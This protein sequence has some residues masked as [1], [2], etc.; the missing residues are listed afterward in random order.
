MDTAQP[1]VAAETDPNAQ[2]A[3]AAEAFKA[4]DSPASV[5][6]RD[7]TGR[8]ASDQ[9]EEELTDDPEYTELVEDGEDVDDEAEEAAEEPAQP[10][11]PSWGADDT[12]LWESLPPEAQARIAEREGERDRGLNQK[13]QEAANTRKAYEQQVQEASS[14]LQELTS[15]IDTVEAIYKAPEPDPRAFGYGTRQYNEAAYRTAYQQWQQ[16]EN[17]L[18]QLHQ[19]REAATAKQNEAEAQAFTEWK[20]QHEAQYAPKLL[21]DVP[22]LKDTA[23]AD[24]VVRAMVD[25]AIANGIPAETFAEEN[26]QAITSAQLHI[27]WKAQ[28]FDRLRANK[29][30]AKPKPAGPAVKPGV[31]SPRSAQKATRQRTAMDRLSREGSIDAGA[32]VFK[33]FF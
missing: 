13:L 28:Q 11:P 21:Q 29:A 20:K 12:E 25:Y 10:M 16:T 22:E 23:K 27:L 32:A 5:Q 31:S 3:N 8:F 24:P 30:P 6:P 14:R 26:Q 2:L 17:V 4:F 15:V 33:Q 19:Q 9:P 7:N 1:I 18:A